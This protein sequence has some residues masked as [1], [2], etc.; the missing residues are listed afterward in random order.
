MPNPADGEPIGPDGDRE[1]KPIDASGSDRRTSAP[2][3]RVAA[4]VIAGAALVLGYVFIKG[5]RPAPEPTPATPAATQLSKRPECLDIEVVY[6]RMQAILRC[7]SEDSNFAK[8]LCE[9]TYERRPACIDEFESAVSC[10]KAQPESG[11]RCDAAGKL[12]V[13][14]TTCPTQ[15]AALRACFQ[16]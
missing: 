10:I 8:S 3:Y 1:N 6:L 7:P 4:V 11:W 12:G 2:L 15:T 9:T 16:N 14:E 13:K 5:K